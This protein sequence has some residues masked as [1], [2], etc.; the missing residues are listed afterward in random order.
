MATP[1]LQPRLR[2]RTA[3]LSRQV[4]SYRFWEVVA[5]WA[6]EKLQHPNVV[7]RVL[8]KGVVRDGLRM[9]SVIEPPAFWFGPEDRRGR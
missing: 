8:A 1:S 7:A 3:S 5:Q 9:Q 2:D 6:E 4:E